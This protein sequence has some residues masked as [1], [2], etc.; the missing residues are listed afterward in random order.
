ML[1]WYIR[2]L[3]TICH[4]WWV[5]CGICAR[6]VVDATIFIEINGEFVRLLRDMWAC[7]ILL[8]QRHFIRN[9]LI[10]LYWTYQTINRYFNYKA[11]LG[12]SRD[13]CISFNHAHISLPSMASRKRKWSI[14][15]TFSLEKTKVSFLFEEK[16]GLVKGK[17]L[18]QLTWDLI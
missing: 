2:L 7:S 8:Q 11:W 15:T 9:A 13:K 14:K 10:K 6:I 18:R 12:H 3:K 16:T 1:Q 17:K 5:G 4:R